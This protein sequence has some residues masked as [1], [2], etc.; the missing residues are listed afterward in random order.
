MIASRHPNACV[1][2]SKRRYLGSVV[3]LKSVKVML[4]LLG[5]FG[6]LPK[7]NRL[8]DTVKNKKKAEDIFKDD[9]FKE[10]YDLCG[11]K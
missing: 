9:V 2:T 11:L 7:L 10:V 6:R 4:D 3:T 1:P 8:G 5:S